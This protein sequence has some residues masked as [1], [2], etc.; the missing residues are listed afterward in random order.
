M[1]MLASVVSNYWP[2]PNLLPFYGILES[3]GWTFRSQKAH[4]ALAF[5]PNAQ[6]FP[7]S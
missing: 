3:Q 7:A 6:T 4:S 2:N 1:F 5:L